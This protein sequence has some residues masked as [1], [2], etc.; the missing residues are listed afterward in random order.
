MRFGKGCEPVRRNCMMVWCSVTSAGQE[1]GEKLLL[2]ELLDC[3]D[4]GIMLL[5]NVG[6]YCMPVGKA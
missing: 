4:G 1:T 2:V 6:K 5:Q 3:Q